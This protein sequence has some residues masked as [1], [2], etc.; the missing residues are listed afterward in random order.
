MFK[1]AI[2]IL[3]IKEMNTV[4]RTKHDFLSLTAKIKENRF[5][6]SDVVTIKVRSFKDNYFISNSTGL[7]FKL[8][9]IDYKNVSDFIS[10]NPKIK[11]ITWRGNFSILQR[12]N[13]ELFELPEQIEYN[14][15]EDNRE[16][17]L[18]SKVFE[19]F[20]IPEKFFKNSFALNGNNFSKMLGFDSFIDEMQVYF[21]DKNINQFTH[22]NLLERKIYI[23]KHHQQV[24]IDTLADKFNS[25]FLSYYNETLKSDYK[26]NIEDIPNS[27]FEII[28]NYI[29]EHY[30]NTDIFIDYLTFNN[31]IQIKG[32]VIKYKE[33]KYYYLN[34][35]DYI[36]YNK[37][38]QYNKDF[39]TLLEE[40]LK[41]KKL[42]NF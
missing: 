21:L 34:I 38:D 3:E 22:F 12:F 27:A 7:L 42:N 17:V 11:F 16:E 39:Y 1:Y 36:E 25:S 33:N 26:S 4:S 32:F 31:S 18:K 23:E 2:E 28:E 9:N 15:K 24:L 41:I 6:K 19:E 37:K 5:L 13:L 20:D 8:N 35:S 40:S 10:N 29:E 30:F 14:S